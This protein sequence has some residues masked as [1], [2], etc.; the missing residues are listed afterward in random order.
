MAEA[1]EPLLPGQVHNEYD[2]PEDEQYYRERAENAVPSV[3]T[4]LLAIRRLFLRDISG[5]PGK[6]AAFEILTELPIDWELAKTLGPQADE[7]HSIDPCATGPSLPT[8]RR[9]YRKRM[10]RH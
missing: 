1:P 6:R 7:Q 9:S 5:C 10:P 8:A 2:E 4:K 3:C